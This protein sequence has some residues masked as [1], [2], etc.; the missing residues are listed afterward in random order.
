MKNILAENM[1]RF[2]VKNLTESEIQTINERRNSMFPMEI[3]GNYDK[4]ITVN[5]WTDIVESFQKGL[6][7]KQ[8]ID[9]EFNKYGDFGYFIYHYDKMGYQRQ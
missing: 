6:I 1:L 9:D 2:G 7:T 8:Q 3:A 4:I 5:N